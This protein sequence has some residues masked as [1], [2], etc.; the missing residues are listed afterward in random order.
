MDIGQA[1]AF[2]LF[3]ATGDL[4]KKLVLPALYQLEASGQLEVPIIGVARSE[5]GAAELAAYAR[6]AVE[7][8]IPHVEPSVMERFLGRLDYV[9]GEYDATATF[10]ELKARIGDRASSACYYLAVPPLLFADVSRALAD[11]GLS[12]NSRLVVEKPFGHDEASARE[13]DVELRK[14][15]DE[16]R[17]FRV[18]HFLGK[19]AVEDI[20]VF[21]FANR[22]FE[23]FW[24]RDHVKSVQITF[25]ETLDVADRGSFYDAVGALRDVLENHLFQVLAYV[26]MDAPA[27]SG[28]E[29]E[30]AERTRLLRSVRTLAPGD[31]VY[32]QYQ[33][34]CEVDGVAADS[35]TDTY[36]AVRLWIDNARWHGVPF[37]VRT[38]KVMPVTALEVVI[39][40]H[41]APPVPLLA[42]GAGERSANLV[43]LRLQPDPG[44]TLDVVA[45]TPG[46]GYPTRSVPLRV[47]FD[48][49]LGPAPMAYERVIADALAGIGVHFASQSSIEEAWRIVDPVLDLA[50]APHLYEPGTW[51]P[52]AA[53][54][55]AG[56]SGWNELTDFMAKEQPR[57]SAR[58]R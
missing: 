15:F 53:D 34:Y 40:L 45:K 36:A 54:E 17:I 58:G 39:E 1:D 43:R 9:S 8:A 35:R 38:G 26:A 28:E 11:E 46:V 10:D 32:G 44:V 19:E 50:S 3:G 2:V 4:A 24:N 21:R 57:G 13:L 33:G 51:G 52:V 20:L 49:L 31:V 14:Y 25:A 16:E 5:W 6:E 30:Q 18:D 56:E 41:P 22:L 42:E 37:L 27:G 23:P 47:D 12:A 29:A 7:A 48:P 55:L